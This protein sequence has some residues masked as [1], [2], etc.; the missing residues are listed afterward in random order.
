ML[1][2]EKKRVFVSLLLL[3]FACTCRVEALPHVFFPAKV[4]SSVFLKMGMKEFANFGQG[5]G[6]CTVAGD[7]LI[8]SILPFILPFI[9]PSFFHPPS[10]LRFIL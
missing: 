5:Y 2:E 8:P 10:Y 6:G 9:F 4:S 7:A 3:H 1:T